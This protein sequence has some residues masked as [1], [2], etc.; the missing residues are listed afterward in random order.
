MQT[1]LE[2]LAHL[3]QEQVRCER[4]L[5][6]L[7]DWVACR[8][9]EG[10]GA[11]ARPERKT[12]GWTE[13]KRLAVSARMRAYWAERRGASNHDTDAPQHQPAHAAANDEAA[14]AAPRARPRGASK[15]W[16]D[17]SRAAAA[18]RMQER[19]QTRRGRS[20]VQGP[21]PPSVRP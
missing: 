8:E 5:R 13:E 17:A 11:Q 12:T 1:L 21:P 20:P 18:R 3:E 10:F 16:S 19:W 7:R 6:E 15:E 2:A 4:R 14:N 9:A